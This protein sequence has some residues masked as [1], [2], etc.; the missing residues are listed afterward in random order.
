MTVPPQDAREP[1]RECD[2]AVIGMAGRF[3]GARDV[4]ELWRNLSNGV[5]S[6]SELT[7]SDLVQA[8]VPRADLE[9]PNYVRARGLLA[10]AECFDAAFFGVTPAE[11]TVMDPQHRLLLECAWAAL[12]HAG[13]APDS[14][15]G[16]VGVYAGA[17]ASDHRARLGSRPELCDLLGGY[18]VQVGNDVDFLTT[19]ISYKLNLKGPSIAVQ[20]S[21]STSLVAVHLACQA[22]L[23]GECDLA[24]AGGVNVSTLRRVGYLY[25]EAGIRSPDGHCRP[26]DAGAKGMVSGAGLGLV[27]IKPLRAALRDRDFVH[28]V[29]KGSAVNND[30]RAKVSY[31]APSVDGQATAI[32][33][34]LSWAAVDPATIGYVEAHGTGTHLG[35]PI[36]IAALTDVFRASTSRRSKCPV[37]SIKANIGHLS[38]A[39]GVAGLIKTILILKHG[40]VPP[41]PYFRAPNPEARLDESPF[42][43]N[44]G[45]VDWPATA[46]PRRALVSAL[47]I[48]GTNA[49]V[50]LEEAPVHA[51][52]TPSNTWHVLTLSART[53]SALD[54]M[55]QNLSGHLTSA[56]A[57]S[58]PDLAHTLHA[59][60]TGFSYRRAITC[61]D[62]DGAVRALRGEEG[63]RAWTGVASEEPP[64]A[65]FMFPGVG[66][67]YVGM[68]A[69]LYREDAMF[70]Q[71]LD[72][73]FDVLARHSD[74]NFRDVLYRPDSQTDPTTIDRAV[75]VNPL[76]FAVAYGVAIRWTQCGIRP[77]ALIG[78]SLGEYAAATLAGVFTL[79][80]ALELMLTRGRLIERVPPGAM[81]AVPLSEEETLPYLND[82][83]SLAS[84]NAPTACILSGAPAAIAAVEAA[85]HQRGT[86]RR[87]LRFPHAPHSAMMDP[88]LGEFAD[89]VR[90]AAPKAPRIPLV[91]SVTGTWITPAQAEDPHY[92]ASHLRRTV[93]FAEGLRCVLSNPRQLLIEMGPGRSLSRLVKR[94]GAGAAK[95]QVIPTLRAPDDDTPDRELFA[96]G[97][98]R[99]WAAGVRVEWTHYTGAEPRYRVPLPTYPFER[100][101][102]GLETS[103]GAPSPSDASGHT[104]RTADDRGAPGSDLERV[105]TDQLRLMSAQLDA[106]QG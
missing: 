20:T 46:H 71:E 64:P 34:A 33:E 99:C 22:L 38:A 39:A 94:Q 48:G 81:L 95:R 15:P 6:I 58:L 98:A 90:A 49:H 105:I 3:P 55:T 92:W 10:D 18:L 29:I 84:V 101:R 86:A 27:V 47:G 11:A 93:R 77:A 83:V 61:R 2:I 35:D 57:P 50:V 31:T 78:H 14:V 43:V 16:V 106:L 103:T 91:S 32:R 12:E 72:R 65:A 45:A 28:A 102:Y 67:Q 7:S 80:H 68:A 76:V 19:R 74:V 51:P 37:G 8:G 73:C 66:T 26:F 79:E 104:A 40:C 4:D 63:A 62:I 60:R 5:E 97:L 41:N 52:T 87:A 1:E 100:T 89:H 36:E 96:R 25:Q 53:A 23:N 85:L 56:A 30:G 88:I 21:C 69:E 9:H 75:V 82:D 24:L 44:Q 17:S 70:R 42:Y 13:Y 59:G 54:A